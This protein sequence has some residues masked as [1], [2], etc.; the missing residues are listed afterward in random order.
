MSAFHVSNFEKVLNSTFYQQ[1]LPIRLTLMQ[2]RH[3][4]F[5]FDNYFTVLCWIHNKVISLNIKSYDK[6]FPQFFFTNQ[7]T[8]FSNRRGCIYYS[9]N[10]QN[11][12]IHVSIML[13]KIKKNEIL[14]LLII[15]LR[16][17]KTYQLQ[18]FYEVNML[19]MDLIGL[20]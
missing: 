11:K 15:F 8:I 5:Y 2:D 12:H 17:V 18:T 9:Y 7:D 10:Q 1:I 4:I 14:L 16:W 13:V 3:S 20:Y 6:Y 19:Y